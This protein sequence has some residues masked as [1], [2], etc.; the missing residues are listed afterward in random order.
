MSCGP[1]SRRVVC[2]SSAP[3]DKL[4]ATNPNDS[5]AMFCHRQNVRL[6]GKLTA[7]IRRVARRR[8]QA[9]VEAGDVIETKGPMTAHAI[10]TRKAGLS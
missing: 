3:G 9:L 1:R 2:D 4:K 6:N 8:Q 5:F 10:G 7:I